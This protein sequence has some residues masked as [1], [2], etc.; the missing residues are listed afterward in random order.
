MHGIIHG[1]YSPSGTNTKFSLILA[2]A[3][4]EKWGCIFHAFI[5]R[6]NPS[7][8]TGKQCQTRRS[9]INKVITTFAW[10]KDICT[11]RLV[12]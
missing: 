12:P 7:S 4:K 9:K 6:H 8:K 2:A 1:V 11:H 3:Q 5:P 10:I